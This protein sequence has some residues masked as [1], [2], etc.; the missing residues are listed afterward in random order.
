[1]STKIAKLKAAIAEE[2]KT[3]L[4]KLEAELKKE[5]AKELYVEFQSPGSLVSEIDSKK[6]KSK[7]LKA[8]ITIAKSIKQ[9]GGASPYGFLFRD[10]NGRQKG[11]FYYITGTLLRYEE[12]PIINENSILRSNMFCNE[13]PIVI[14]NRNSYRITRPFEKTDAIVDWDGNIIIKGNDKELVAYRNEFLKYKGKE[15]KRARALEGK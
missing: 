1:M 12:V 14:E 9:R 2:K 8:V 5:K 7:D 6:V 4:Q 10:G 11:F 13:W 15:G 3:K